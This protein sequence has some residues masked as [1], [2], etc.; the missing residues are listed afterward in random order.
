MGQYYL[1]YVN[2]SQNGIKQVFDNEVDDDYNGLKLMEHSWWRNRYVG[3]VVNNLFYERKRVCWVGDYYD[4]DGYA[5]V[6]CDRATVKE[7]GEFVWGEHQEEHL[8][9]SSKTRVRFLDGC[10]LVNHTKKQFII[11]DDYYERNKFIE[12]W[13][14][15]DYPCVIH[16]LPLLTCSAS[17][18]GGS[19]R[20]TN[21]DLCGTWFND[22]IEVV[23]DSEIEPL[24]E[25]GYTEVL[26][27]FK[28]R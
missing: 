23:L 9:K 11:C 26:P 13:S 8:T 28:E 19:Y 24:T 10:L 3:N 15:K 20:G 2:D 16:P 17:H 18:S 7:I 4:E 25:Q 14:G 22:E 6:N 1:G 12:H 5:Q 21:S 27:E